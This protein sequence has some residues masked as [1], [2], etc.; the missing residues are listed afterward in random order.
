VSLTLVRGLRA[1]R[2]TPCRTVTVTP[3]YRD[4]PRGALRAYVDGYRVEDEITGQ[5]RHVPTFRRAREV[6]EHF[7]A[8]RPRLDWS[9]W[10]LGTQNDCHFSEFSSAD[11]I[12]KVTAFAT[13]APSRSELTGGLF[14][15][16][17]TAVVDGVE[18]GTQW[19][20]D[21]RNISQR[22]AHIRAYATAKTALMLKE[23]E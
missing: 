8:V 7:L 18:Y 21:I 10:M 14:S 4:A 11:G 3:E 1:A 9:E 20:T 12:V 2:H 19:W 22:L 17:Y 16:G 5:I 23:M 13:R 15:I 6:A